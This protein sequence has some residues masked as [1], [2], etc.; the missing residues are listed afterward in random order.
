S[1]I[2][3]SPFGYQLHQAYR[4]VPRPS[5]APIT[6]ASTVRP[7]QLTQ[8][9]TPQN[10]AISRI[11]RKLSKYNNQTKDGYHHTDTTITRQTP[12]PTPGQ[13]VELSIRCSRPLYS[14]H[15]TT[16]PTPTTT[17]TQAASMPAGTTIFY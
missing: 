9:T 4:R 13:H 5:S 15:H 2:L 16:P 7:Y 6:K 3:A 14:Y 8:P 12:Q 11:S 17:Q 10:R 1:D